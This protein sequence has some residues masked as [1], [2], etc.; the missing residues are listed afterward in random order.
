MAK[1]LAIYVLKDE[2]SDITLYVD[3]PS[4]GPD[5]PLLSKYIVSNG[6]DPTDETSLWKYIEFQGDL[7]SDEIQNHKS[8]GQSPAKLI[9]NLNE[10]LEEMSGE[11]QD[12]M[13]RVY[14]PTE[15]PAAKMFKFLLKFRGIDSILGLQFYEGDRPGSSMTY[16]TAQDKAVVEQLVAFLAV[17]GVDV[18]IRYFSWR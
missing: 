11:W 7:D 4:Q 14:E 16:V 5:Y 13:D 12:W 3:D 6:F 15:S 17:N 10:P 2:E 18:S 9:G 8:E 1:D